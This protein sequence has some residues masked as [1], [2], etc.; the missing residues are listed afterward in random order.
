MSQYNGGGITVKTPLQLVTSAYE[1]SQADKY[2]ATKVFPNVT[3][4]KRTG[5]FWKMNPADWLRNQVQKRAAG[6]VAR[7]G[8]WRF[9]EGPLWRVLEYT[10]KTGVPRQDRKE[11]MENGLPD[12]QVTNRRWVLSQLDLNRELIFASR[13]MAAGVWDTEWDGEASGIGAGEFLHWDDAAS[14]PIEDV[15]EFLDTI[16]GKTGI[17]P[18]LAI[19]PRVVARALRVNPQMVAA[20]RVPTR[21][22][23]EF[24]ATIDLIRQAWDIPNVIVVD[25]VYNTAGPMADP[26]LAQIYGKTVGFFVVGDANFA[27]SPSAGHIISWSDTE[28]G[29]SENGNVLDEWYERDTK[30][31]ITEGS[32]FHDMLITSNKL[33]GIMKEAVS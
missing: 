14:T 3:V 33:G 9:Q 4:K 12:P 15:G 31:F 18:N 1:Q 27:E 19:V 29:T 21:S 5:D 28:E 23:G 10:A 6:T 24:L 13:F 32:Q 7:R 30:S 16:H 17:T 2:I 20:S 11:Q 26:T 22:D 8:G 25:S